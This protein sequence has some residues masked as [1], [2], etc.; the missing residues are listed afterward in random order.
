MIRYLKSSSKINTNG[1]LWLSL[2]LFIVSMYNGYYI[3]NGSLLMTILANR[4]FIL[5]GIVFLL[6][7][8][9]ETYEVSIEDI[10]SIIIY[11]AL[12]ISFLIFVVHIFRL[13]I[14][15]NAV[16]PAFT[17]YFHVGLIQKD[18]I[19]V[20]AYLALSLSINTSR[21]KVK[22]FLYALVIT[23]TNHLYDLQRYA[24]LMF[25]FMFAIILI[26]RYRTRFNILLIFMLFTASIFALRLIGLSQDSYALDAIM[27]DSSL[28]ARL[29]EIEFALRSFKAKPF[30][31]HGL[32]MPSYA[33]NILHGEYFYPTDV[34]VFGVLFSGGGLGLLFLILQY[35]LLYRIWCSRFDLNY[36]FVIVFLGFMLLSVL[37]AKSYN[38]MAIFFILL[39]LAI[40]RDGKDYSSS[41]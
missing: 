30:I 10:S 14:S 36:H 18:F 26:D 6:Q 2:V 25:I 40:Q 20:A 38:N 34:G 31:G 33:D 21:F 9:M 37:S 23:L 41:S 39:I 5:I 4:S 11:F 29:N 8:L 12:C 17:P 22:F 13:N 27:R 1:L 16:L 15:P 35:K 32:Y 24:L 7:N 28:V 3:H 19:N